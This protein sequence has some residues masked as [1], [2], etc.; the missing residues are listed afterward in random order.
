MDVPLRSR[1]VSTS[2]GRAL[3]F[4]AFGLFA[5]AIMAAAPGSPFQPLLTWQ[6]QPTGPLTALARV[7]G[8][9]DLHGNALLV[10][11]V[12]VSALA[13]VSFLH[14]LREAF[15]GRV[16]LRAVVILVVG[17]HV[18]LL[19][20]PLLFSRDAYSYAFY[21]RI[22]GVYGGNPYVQTPLDHSG[23]LLWNYVGAKW[24]DTPAVYGPAW[25]TLSAGLSKF[26][27]RPVDH[28]E[29]YR[30]LAIAASLATSAAIVWVV[31]RERPD[32]AAFALAAFGAN[33]VV[34]F[35]AAGSGHND[36][37]VALAIVSAI[38]LV[39][40]RHER[41]A[42]AVLAV[43]ALVK[44]VALLPL[45]L[46]IVWAIARRPEDQR[47][48]TLVSYGGL[49]AT[50]ALAFAVP[51]LQLHDPTLGMLELASHEGWLAPSASIERIVN[52]VSFETVGGLVRIGFAA[53][54]VGLFVALCR[55]VWRRAASI[56]PRELA[57]SWAWALLLLTLLGPVLLPWY[58]VWTLP[59]VWALPRTG[60]TALV[61][62]GAL[63]GVTLWSA[64][65]LR[66]PGGFTVNVIV[67][68]W[69]VV[70]LFVGLLVRS[71]RDL[72]ARL[73]IGMSL[74]DEGPPVLAAATAPEREPVAGAAG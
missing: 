6:G 50:I 41:A 36:L 33:P 3:A 57:T 11:S 44:A 28:V 17:A 23:D 42:V 4:A 5:M 7:L 2:G 13:A 66:F 67:A 64:E 32:R 18:A 51:Y 19:L 12:A 43:G 73:A 27:P 10:T 71:V 61:T 20:L 25:S 65:P 53:L 30:L 29:A 15:R 48:A 35:H 74:G 24:V 8:L 60:R 68:Q 14:L 58:V 22:A 47:R 39:A 26:Y 9:D 31:R 37:L 46:L 45:V 69:V 34:L 55:D 63:L 70:P 16:S 40:R 59:L 38:G 1:T 21:G 72:R 62:V 54:L 52:L 56:E 49:A